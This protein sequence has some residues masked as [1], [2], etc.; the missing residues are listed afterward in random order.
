MTVS[1]FKELKANREEPDLNKAAV[2]GTGSDELEEF[3]L[4]PQDMLR[5]VPGVTIHNLNKLTHN[6]SNFIDLCKNFT[7]P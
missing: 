5:K 1:L 7:K 6:Y 3:D 2:I 4:T